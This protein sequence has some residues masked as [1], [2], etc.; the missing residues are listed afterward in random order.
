M[1]EIFLIITVAVLFISMTFAV[2]GIKTKSM[3]TYGVCEKLFFTGI[4]ISG[5]MMITTITMLEVLL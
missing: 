4:G 2:I 1:T 5:F 3:D